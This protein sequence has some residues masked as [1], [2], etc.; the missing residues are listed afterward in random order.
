MSPPLFCLI[1]FLSFRYLFIYIL[2][3]NICSR[4]VDKKSWNLYLNLYRKCHIISLAPNYFFIFL[5]DSTY[6]L[7]LSLETID[8][9]L[10]SPPSLLLPS[11]LSPFLP[12]KTVPFRLPWASKIGYF[13]SNSSNL[14]SASIVPKLVARTNLGEFW[15]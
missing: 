3:R 1:F 11:S 4:N 14:V 12:F 9:K 13:L 6:I 8:A 5:Q 10:L 7:V 2:S 15:S